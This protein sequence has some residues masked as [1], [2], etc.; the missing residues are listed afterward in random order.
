MTVKITHYLYNTYLIETGSSKIAIDPGALFLHYFRLTTLIPKS[1]WKG[2]THV[3]ITH[4][5]PD[6]Y[7]HAD[8][9]VKASGAAVICN[10]TM[11]KDDSGNTLMLDPRNKGLTFTTAMKNVHPIAVDETLELDGMKVSGIKATHGKLVLRLG[12]FSKTVTPGPQE[13]IGWG[14][15]GF[16]I[17]LEGKSIVNLGDTL[18]HSEEWKVINRPDVLMLP[19][20]GKAAHNTMD[21]DEAL[22][23]VRIMKPAIVLPCHYNCPGFFTSKYNPADDAYFK[24]EVEKLGSKCII[25]RNAESVDV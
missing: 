5:D 16:N 13:R 14:A 19:I 25:L 2:I 9:V 21:E 7:W 1:E 4:G 20:G 6:H 10:R 11:L 8:R 22:E 15:I 12:P 23:A 17:R 24:R 3:F 18:L